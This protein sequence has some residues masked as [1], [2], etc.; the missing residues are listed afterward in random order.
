VSESELLPEHAELTERVRKR[1]RERMDKTRRALPESAAA[2]RSSKV[3]EHLLALPWLEEA[4]SVALFWPLSGRREVDLR[5]LDAELMRRGVARYY[6]FMD[7]SERG[8]TTGFRRVEHS[9]E[10]VRRGRVFAEPPR[11]APTARTGDLDLVLVPALAV[12]S[13]GHR[14]GFGTGFYDVTL[15]DFCP[16]ARSVV[17]A[18]SFQVLIE[19]PALPHDV[20]CDLVVT[21]QHVLDPRESLGGD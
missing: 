13:A 8:V 21:D 5:A 16:P 7:P 3:V 14:L 19:L 18:F 15:P 11:D 9:E 10:L 4:R 17:V 1:L 6:P 12:S 2:S 20:A